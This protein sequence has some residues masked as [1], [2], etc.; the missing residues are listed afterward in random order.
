M[1]TA[2][3]YMILGLAGALLATS[4]YEDKGNYDYTELTDMYVDQMGV[5]TTLTVLQYSAVELPSHLVYQGDRSKLEFV[6]LAYEASPGLAGNPCDTLAT[7]EKLS[8]PIYL[9]PD[10]YVI[11][12]RATEKATGRIATAL[13]DLTVESAL[14][15]GLLVMYEKDGKVDCDMIKA[16][17]LMGSV[18]QS[19][20]MRNVFTSTNSHFDPKGGA[21]CLGMYSS[22][23]IKYIYLFTEGNGA[24]L[25]PVD[26][27]QENDFNG[28]FYAA[29][30]VAKPQSYWSPAYDGG[31]T[32]EGTAMIV[33][34]G[35]VHP[36]QGAFASIS[37]DT[38][39]PFGGYVASAAVGK[40]EAA[41]WVTYGSG[42]AIV[43]DQLGMRFLTGG[44][45]ATELNPISY[46]AN[47]QNAKFDLRNIGKKMVYMSNGYGARTSPT[48]GRIMYAFFR[49]PT[50]DGKR[51][52]YIIDFSAGAS[53]FKSLALLDISA[54]ENIAKA[55][56]YALGTRGAVL[57]YAAENN[58]YQ[59]KYDPLLA[60]DDVLG[61][62]KAWPYIPA[63]EKVTCIKL[64]PTSGINLPTGSNVLDKYL[65]VATYKE[66]TK[67][68]KIYM[69]EMNV[70][71]GDLEREPA[72]VFTQFGKVKDMLF[73][74]I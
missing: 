68:G 4:C 42:N 40:Y 16:K 41:P 2:F 73:K 21:V 53:T 15:N 72:A 8:A 43:Y 61:C 9:F 23:T 44:A 19:Y 38:N 39:P 28:I 25:S 56:S 47:A 27:S 30:S 13:Y 14:G 3:K 22:A 62:V 26:L 74:T 11:Q 52:L 59:I 34:N 6:W 48:L 36:C 57:F 7:T 37:G 18:A 35:M 71:S 12:F 54:C 51:W 32:T 46:A 66:S 63:D 17:E 69:L 33:N 50:D 65:F 10:K 45:L 5:A 55:E 70:S 24:R 60:G 49:N 1:K 31:T 58:V 20:V 64:C 67:E 29:P